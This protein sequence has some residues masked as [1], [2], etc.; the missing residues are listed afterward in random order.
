MN[1]YCFKKT[2]I[3][4]K[5]LLALEGYIRALFYKSKKHNACIPLINDVIGHYYYL[6]LSYDFVE[7]YGDK[8]N[9]MI[10]K[11]L[12]NIIIENY[13]LSHIG[14]KAQISTKMIR[15]NHI[16]NIL[17]T[18]TISSTILKDF[19]DSLD[20]E[21]NHFIIEHNEIDNTLFDYFK[22]KN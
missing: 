1:E 19:A 11:D 4:Q 17:K 18:R 15:I 2:K 8:M 13:F 21:F 5:Y 12:D 16:H 20:G 3:F 7:T 14:K 10:N 9:I 6:L 22:K